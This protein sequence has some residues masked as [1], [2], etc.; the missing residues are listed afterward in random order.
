MKYQLENCILQLNSNALKKYK[1]YMLLDRKK[2][3]EFSLL[4]VVM[5]A[6]AFLFC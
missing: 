4:L 6:L 1:R 3:E 5:E 2:E